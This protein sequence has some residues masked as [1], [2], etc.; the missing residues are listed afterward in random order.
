MNLDLYSRSE[1]VGCNIVINRVQ[2][3]KININNKCLDCILILGGRKMNFIIQKKEE[4]LEN[5]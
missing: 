5:L 2:N 3:I 4:G 1:A